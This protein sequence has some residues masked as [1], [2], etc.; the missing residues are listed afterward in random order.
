MF[1]RVKITNEQK[2]NNWYFQRK[3]VI[4][5]NNIYKLIDN[6]LSK[7][8]KEGSISECIDN[9][10]N[11]HLSFDDGFKEHLKVAYLLKERYN[12]DCN[13]VSFSINIANSINNDFAG[14]DLVYSILENNLIEKLNQF[15]ETDF[16]TKNIPEIKKYIASLKPEQLKQLSNYF[17]ELHEQLENTFLNK[18]EII[19][20]SKIFK[21]TSHGISHR[22]LTNHKKESK[23]EILQSKT[24][25]ESIINQ[26][27]DTFCYP[28]GKNNNELQ[29]Y[30]KKAGYKY[31]LSIRHEE[32]NKFCIGR[33]IM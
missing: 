32:N 11:F 4:E 20:L 26:N 30:C 8:Y 16:N 25:L 1:H 14:M 19:E 23:K 18:T 3:M 13:S 6:Y 22:F 17:L 21:I 7:G 33:K 9:N 12:F 29:N 27:I 15:F 24:I 31:A 5:I 2:I 28:E 10:N